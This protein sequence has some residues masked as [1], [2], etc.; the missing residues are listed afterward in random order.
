MS[1]QSFVEIAKDSGSSVLSSRDRNRM[2]DLIA[3]QTGKSKKAWRAYQ[4]KMLAKTAE[5]VA[6]KPCSV[7]EALEAIKGI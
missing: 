4:R 7:Q 3:W 1:K 6:P 2:A 5:R